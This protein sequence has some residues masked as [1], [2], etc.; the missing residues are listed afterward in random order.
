MAV[1]GLYLLDMGAFQSHAGRW[2][3]GSG[4]GRKH[5]SVLCIKKC[6]SPEVDVN[7]TIRPWDIGP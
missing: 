4:R 5:N 7:T 2:V 3:Y 1:K 6:T